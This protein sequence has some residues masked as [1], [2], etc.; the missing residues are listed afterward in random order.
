MWSFE[1]EKGAFEVEFRCDA[2]NH[3]ICTLYPAHSHWTCDGN[4]VSISWGKYHLLI[5][6]L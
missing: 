5:H 3:F 6:A 4:V 2:L 1:Y